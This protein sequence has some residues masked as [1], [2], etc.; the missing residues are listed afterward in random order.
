[1]NPR[2]HRLA[3]CFG[4][5]LCV[6]AAVACASTAAVAD[7][8]YP[9][10]PIKWL[11]GYP[12]GGG[13]DFLARTIAAQLSEQ[14]K[15]PVL[16]DNRPGAAGMIGAEAAARS[17]AD[18]Y[19]VFTADNGILIYNP[20]LY[21]SVS[22][23][24]EKDYAP[25]GLLARVPLVLVSA[26][27][28]GIKDLPGALSMLKANP[29]STVMRRRASAVLITWPWSFSSSAPVSLRYIS[30]TGVPRPRCRT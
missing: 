19:T 8:P 9:E 26:S 18:G 28:T 21:K 29:A 5:Y 24:P 15:Q 11:V 25:V 14:V 4:R 2:L 13:S 7:G 30:L 27:S 6:L 23:N 20:A 10:R 12:A 3:R 1:M 16:I 17:P 22:Y